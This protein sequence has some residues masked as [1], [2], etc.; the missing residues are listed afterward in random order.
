MYWDVLNIFNKVKEGINKPKCNLASIGVDTW[1]VD[2]GVLDKFGQ[3]LSN[4]FRYRDNRTNGIQLQ[5]LH[6]KVPT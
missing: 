1:G 2:F 4:P 3:L 5:D 6:L